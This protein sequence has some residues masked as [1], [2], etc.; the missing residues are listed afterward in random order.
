MRSPKQ[1]YAEMQQ[2]NKKNDKP[3]INNNKSYEHKF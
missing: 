3:S 1:K 2:K